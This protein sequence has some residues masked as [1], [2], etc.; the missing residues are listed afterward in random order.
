MLFGHRGMTAEVKVLTF[1]NEDPYHATNPSLRTLRPVPFT[2][3]LQQGHDVA[4]RNRRPEKDL[5]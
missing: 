5:V 3:L 1:H 4:L 2:A